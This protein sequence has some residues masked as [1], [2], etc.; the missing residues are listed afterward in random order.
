ML[1]FKTWKAKSVIIINSIEL[2]TTV[3][4]IYKMI[5]HFLKKK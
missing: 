1:F 4:A 5:G 2:I 3:I